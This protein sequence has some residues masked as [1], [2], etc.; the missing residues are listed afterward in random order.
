[1]Y[2]TTERELNTSNCVLKPHLHRS[3][4]RIFREI[5]RDET[6]GFCRVGY[7]QSSLLSKFS[8]PEPTYAA[9]RKSAAITKLA[10]TERRNRRTVW[11]LRN[12]RSG[13]IHGVSYSTLMFTAR[14]IIADI[15]G[16]VD[17][18]ELFSSA[19][20]SNG[21]SI[22]KRRTESSKFEKFDGGSAVTDSALPYLVTLAR[23]SATLERGFII[24][25]CYNKAEVVTH[26]VLFTV[27]KNEKEDRI[28]AKEPDW[29]MFFQKGLG[30]MIRRRLRKAGI[31]LN[32]QSR[33]RKLAQLGSIDGSL[34]TIDL[35]SASDSVTEQLVYE[36]LPQ[37][38]FYHLSNL[39]SKQGQLLDGSSHTW[40]LFSTMGNGFTFELESLIFFALAK[41]ITYHFGVKGQ[42]S[43]YGD[44]II[45]PTGASSQLIHFL[46]YC[47][48]IT[49][50]E[51]SFTTGFFRESC[52]GHF[53]K[54]IDVTPIYIRRPITS[55]P[56]LIGIINKFR[57]WSG[58]NTLG[59]ND[60][61]HLVIYKKLE[62]LIPKGIRKLITGGGNTE[63]N[64]W[65]CGEGKALMRIAHKVSNTKRGLNKSSS[66]CLSS[67]LYWLTK[68]K[69]HDIGEAVKTGTEKLYLRKVDPVTMYYSNQT[70]SYRWFTDSGVV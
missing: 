34:S 47:G 11:R 7:L 33:N 63:Q 31:D 29:N 38:W 6:E 17:V 13:F 66:L 16:D 23:A 28:A 26:N 1:M 12:R 44:D 54:G 69:D 51:K 27:P 57:R 19:D 45:V 41:S 9:Q 42:V 5:E 37:D 22:S 64:Q 55:Y 68:R 43:V 46:G 61:R 14:K 65:I 58:V 67:Y 32:D 24:Q 49:N 35:S 36:L 39:R 2:H 15:L 8:D 53:Y 18:D 62:S 70:P 56:D 25:Q 59:I 30:S 40:V 3:V 50:K 4:E 21:A 48:F 60:P 10:N 52:G 20:F